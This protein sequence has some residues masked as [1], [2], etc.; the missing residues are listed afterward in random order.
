MSLANCRVFA[1]R[2]HE[3]CGM[4]IALYT[5]YNIRYVVVVVVVVVVIIIIII[6]IKGKLKGKIV[7][8]FLLN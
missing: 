2:M 4:N 8:C 6:I 5:V 7:L 3:M 1:K